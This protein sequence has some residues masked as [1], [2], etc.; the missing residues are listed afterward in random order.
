M[1]KILSN[2][3]NF[4]EKQVGLESFYEDSEK[5]F[6]NVW[7]SGSKLFILIYIFHIQTSSLKATD[8]IFPQQFSF[9]L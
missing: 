5:S 8:S 3:L 4:W 9:K 6:I 7:S 1:K 2:L